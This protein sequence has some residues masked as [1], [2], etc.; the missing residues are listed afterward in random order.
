F[1]VRSR[2]LPQEC[3]IGTDR[4]QR[5]LEY[6]SHPSLMPDFA[7]DIMAA[8]IRHSPT[9]NYA[10]ALSYFHTVQPV[11]RNPTS[12]ELLFTAMASTSLSQAL[13]YSRTFSPPTRELLF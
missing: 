5:A 3:S 9:N 2:P 12:L 11:L 4:S 7:D 8:L 10:L 1:E 6:I 13:H